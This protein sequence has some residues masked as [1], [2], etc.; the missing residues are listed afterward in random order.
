MKT[1]LAKINKENKD[2]VLD[3]ASK[4]IVDGGLVAFPTETVYGLGA[5][6]TNEGA[7]SKIFEVKKRKKDN[8]LI[9]HVA[10]ID[11]VYDLVKEVSEDQ[12]KLMENLWPGPMTLIFKASEKINPTVTAGGDTVAIRMPKDQISL[13]LI[14]RSNKAIAAPSAN[15]STRPS[16]TNAEDVMSDLDGAIDMVIDGGSSKIGI[17]STVIDLIEKPYTI[18][19]PGYYTAEDFEKYLENV[20]YDSALKDQDKIPKSPGQK[21]KH[22]APDTKMIVILGDRNNFKNYIEKLQKEYDNNIGYILTRESDEILNLDNTMV[23]SSENNLEDYSHN[24]FT[25]IRK[26]DKKG[27][28]LILVEGVAEKDLGIGIMNRIRKSC[29]NNLIYL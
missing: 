27:F 6:A 19:R 18:L 3:E 22:Y 7:C 4:I 17:E 21:Y 1:K 29:S 5:D 13:E 2:K 11:M 14:K 26:M 12:R 25:Y 20:I 28:S 8:P 24:I 16:P 10:S 9:V 23:I 15:I